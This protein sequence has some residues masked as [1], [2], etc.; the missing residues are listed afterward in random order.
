VGNLA[1]MA[2]TA[3]AGN[4]TRGFTY[5]V[6]S[7]RLLFTHVNGSDYGYA[8]HP[9]HGYLV[10]MPH[11][12]V[13][14][15]G[16]RDE[17]EAV[18]TQV[19]NQGTPETTWYV[20]DGDGTR[21]RKVV[22]RAAAQGAVPL[23]K[24]ERFYLDGVEI[25]IEYDGA[26]LP[27]ME[28]HTFHV[29]DDHQR[30]A[31]IETEHVPG[32]P[33]PTKRLVRYLSP[34]HLDSTQVETD[35]AG[36]VIAYEVF[37]P[38]GSSAYQATASAVGPPARR[39]R[40]TGMERDE[41]SGLE[42]HGARYYAAWLGR[43]IAPDEHPDTLDGNRFAYVKN[44]PMAYRDPNGRFE[45]PVHGA[46]TY[47]L[48][49]AAGFSAEDAATIAIATAGMDHDAKLRPGD[50]VGEMQSQILLGRTQIH[51]YP[52][53][54]AALAR[55]EGDI[56]DGVDDLRKFGRDIHSLEDVGFKDAAG[57]HSRG[58]SWLAPTL[59]VASAVGAGLGVLA[60]VGAS[61]AFAAGGAWTVA[62]VVLTV[63]AVALFAFALYALI[64]G[65]VGAGTGHPT[66]KTEKEGW[67]FFF[68]HTADRAFSDP[69]ANT[70]ELQRVFE[71]LKAAAKERNPAAV[72][73]EADAAAAI[74]ETVEANTQQKIDAL[75]NTPARD[76]QGKCVASYAEIRAHAPW[77]EREP[78]VSFPKEKYIWN[79]TFMTCPVR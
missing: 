41:E 1:E 43:W 39:Y 10:S 61:K 4:W 2:H 38:F 33:A 72:A 71:K 9:A 12:S 31:L 76:S 25:A 60:A 13:M 52:S 6:D 11:L 63:V 57:P 68:L 73:N 35:D 22:E 44:N 28:R 18:A 78:D 66:Y 47:R 20:Y 75:F 53:Q 19:V 27:S 55:V 65:L 7:N 37:H 70:K 54:E 67:S 26:G 14:R 46:L 79:K 64:F 3:N 15:W 42:Y 48:A 74:K 36:N 17:L 45:E 62:G 29:N 58:V 56:K 8:S 23:K 5:A 69:E 51:H 77:A 24:V 21:V 32:N 50:G 30:V 40:Y 49:L 34:D 59:F 16:V